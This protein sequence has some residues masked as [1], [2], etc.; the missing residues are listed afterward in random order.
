MIEFGDWIETNKQ[1]LDDD[2]LGLFHDS[3]NCYK[4]DINRPSY[5]MAYQG[6]MQYVRLIVLTSS[7]VPSGISKTDWEKKWLEP[8]RNDDTWDGMAFN[9]TQ[10]TKITIMNIPKEAR[11]KFAFWRQFRNVC[12]HYKGYDINKAHTMALYSFIEQYL[13]TL[14]VEGGRVSLNNVF[15]DFY[16]PAITSVHEDIKP[17]LS[18]I[19]K[20]IQDDE[21]KDFFS[22]VDYSCRKYFKYTNRFYEFI[23]QVIEYCP[24][25]VKEELVKFVQSDKKLRDDYLEHY[26]EDVLTVLTGTT[27]IHNYWYSQLPCSQKKII[28]LSLLLESD[29]IPDADKNEAM[30]KCLRSANEFTSSSE[31]AGVKPELSKVLYDK[32]F[33]DL[34]YNYYFNKDYTSRNAQQICYKTDFYIGIIS[35]IP[36]DKKY[37][38]QL[39]AVFSEQFYPYTLQDRLRTMYRNDSEYKAIIDKICKDEGLTLPTIIV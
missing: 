13:F 28:I 29:S 7:C 12:A 32:G 5:L 17:L 15:D 37:V 34:F 25:R 14:S 2:V 39:I 8:L 24:R 16:N 6:M 22:E 31:Y 36:W 3:Y 11:E 26:P 35:L 19:D 21:F 18:M 1:L 33:F 9:C 27:N 38:E 23:H 30:L 20:I 4:N 10:T